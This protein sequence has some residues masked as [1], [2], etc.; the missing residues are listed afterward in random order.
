[1]CWAEE[2]PLEKVEELTEANIYKA[3]HSLLF[4]PM[5]FD[6]IEIKP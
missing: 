1:M 5:G 3:F 2:Q 4:P 6:G